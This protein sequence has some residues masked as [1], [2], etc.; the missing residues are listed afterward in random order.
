MNTSIID[1]SE[2]RDEDE[3]PAYA[4][5]YSSQPGNPFAL[6]P[7]AMRWSDRIFLSRLE[8]CRSFWLEHKKKL[9]CK[10][11]DLFDPLLRHH[12]GEDYI[13]V[14]AN[15]PW[16]CLLYLQYQIRHPGKGL[17]LLGSRLDQN[18]YRTLD[19]DCWFDTQESLAIHLQA[20]NAR[21]FQPDSF[22]ARQARM[23]RF[24]QRIG[25]AAPH[26]MSA[27]DANSIMRRFGKWLGRIWQWS[28]TGT[29]ELQDFPWI[30][31]EPRRLPEVKRDLDY[32]VNQWAYIEVLL[33]D[34][35]AR[36]CDQFQHSD[37]VHINRML[38]EVTLYND[39][40]ISVDLSFRHPYSLHRDQP[41]FDT[42]LYQAR[43]VYD[44]L[45]RDLQA[46]E[47]DL[48]LPEN[49]PF[50]CWR[51]LVCER[52]LLAPAL[53][54]LFSAESEQIDYRQIMNLQNKLPVAFEC[55]QLKA[56]FY[57]ERSFRRVSVGAQ[58][59]EAFDH[60]AWA[61]ASAGKPLF[62]FENPQ[63]IDNPLSSHGRVRK[64]FL[65][66]N[67]SQWWLSQSALQSIRDYFILKDAN[68]RRSWAYRNQDGEWFK[69]GE[70]N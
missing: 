40:K 69:Q 70:Y 7:T 31:L 27:A 15:H 53:W 37:C 33:R 24:I 12:C 5:V 64:I 49:M 43:Y 14:F 42:V 56:S 20:V 6:S 23:R 17:Y 39:K 44:D 58:I 13:A 55:F 62:Y 47:H 1:L 30:R 2:L 41:G 16:Q 60:H 22:R 66:R 29:S 3:F 8:D 59:E 21:G 35:F 25:V 26:E 68:G 36:L 28:F 50:L 46:R 54:D 32:P 10:L 67:S 34:D 52:V 9:C 19:W 18:I 65:E 38:W 57:P 11:A 51:V 48:D 4:A 61:C 45:M 63:P